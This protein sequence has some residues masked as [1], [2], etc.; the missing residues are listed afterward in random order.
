MTDLTIARL[1]VRH[2][3]R[4]AEA[5][6]VFGYH[7]REGAERRARQAARLYQRGL[8]P[9][10]L[11]S[12]GESEA[13]H[14]AAVAAAL[15][16]PGEAILIE[17]LSRTTFE[18]VINSREVLRRAGLLAGLRTL[19]L[20]S[21]PWHMGRTLRIVKGAFPATVE[22]LCCPQEEDC[23]EESWQDC[24]EC[25]RRVRAEAELL[26]NLISAGVLP[27]EV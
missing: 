15:G 24:P 26:D 16:V 21:C 12:G 25:R 2:E 17:A 22:A 1:F 4:P 9:R 3:P 6:L 13:E 18:N 7:I 27:A 23:T 5:A 19:L 20:V 10:L 8:V 11:L 14:M